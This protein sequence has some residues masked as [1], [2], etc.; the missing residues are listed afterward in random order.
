MLRRAG[1]DGVAEGVEARLVGGDLLAGGVLQAFTDDDD[2]MLVLRGDFLDA[3]EERGLVER[4]L[5]QQDDVGR[6]VFVAPVAPTT[7]T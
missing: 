2:A 4:D 5:R 6:V 7:A 3:R 1:Q